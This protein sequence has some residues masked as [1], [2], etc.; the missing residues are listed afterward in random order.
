ME[1]RSSL[2]FADLKGI[3]VDLPDF[4]TFLLNGLLLGGYY[5]L[6]ATGIAIVFGILEIGDVAQGGLFTLGA[7]L[8]YSV[9]SILGLNYFLSPLVVV[10]ITAVISIV[11]GTVVYRRLK[12]YGIAPTFLGAVSLLLVLQSVIALI[13]GERPKTVDSPLVPGTV[14]VGAARIFSHKLLVIAAALLIALA[15]WYF[16]KNTRTGKSLRAVTENREAASLVGINPARATVIA[17]ALAGGLSGLAGFLTAPVYPITPFAGRLAVLKAFVIS[18]LALGSVPAVIAMAIFIG[19][20]ESLASGYFFG[21]LSNLIPFLLLVL[22]ALVRPATIGPN[23]SF[24]TRNSSSWRISFSLPGGKAVAFIAGLTVLAIPFLFDLPAYFIHLAISAGT[25]AMAV[26]GVDLLYG[27]VGTP[28]LVQG[29]LFGVGGYASALLTA[30]YGS[31]ALFALAAGVLVTLAA[32]AFLGVLGVRTGKHWTSF[33]F[34]MTIVFT[35]TM[36]NLGPLTGGPS[37]IPGV[38]T[39]TLGLPGIGRIAF[40]PFGDTRGFYLLVAV[41]LGFVLL[42]KH[43]LVSSWF[44]RSLKAV[45]ENEILAESVGIPTTLYKVLG[46]TAAA[47]FAG[48][49]GVLYAHYV[50]YIHPELFNFVSSFEFLLMNRLG[51]L[52]TLTGPLVGPAFVLTLEEL[53]RPLSPYLGRILMSV[54]L[55]LTLLYLPGGLVGFLK[56]TAARLLPESYVQIV[57]EGG[58]DGNGA[59]TS[60]EAGGHNG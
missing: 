56:R 57:G 18:R 10:P 40:N 11:F 38:R 44:G 51:G 22:V 20:A 26:T 14:R 28:T 42:L 1:T 3:V 2:R 47:G 32:G 31:S 58:D 46:F 27:Y 41:T 53:T 4:I 5:G 13:Y 55:I 34:V 15:V 54:L 6:L 23:E 25:A 29:A 19:V 17:F 9:T 52:G 7:Y 35:I 49:G 12:N 33:T 37:G 60:G 59:T 45:R 43:W 39:L 48:A 24:R 8:T 21:E 36:T 50:T 16:L 30:Q